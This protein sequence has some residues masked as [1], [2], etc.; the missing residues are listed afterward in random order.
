MAGI[1]VKDLSVV[2]RDSRTGSELKVLDSLNF[3]VDDGKLV[4]IL[5]IS[6]CGK[7]TL[8]YT[9]GGLQKQTSGEVIFTNVRGSKDRVTNMVFQEPALFPW[10]TL[11]S[12]VIFGQEMK[13]KDKREAKERA[14]KYLN[15]LGL[16]GFEDK[17]PIQLSGGMKQRAAIARALTNDPEI[18]LM[19]E[20]FAS[21]DA[22]TRWMMQ[23]Q[24][25]DIQASTRKTILFVTHNIEEAIFLADKVIL[26]TARPTKVKETIEIKIPRPRTWDTRSSPEFVEH[27]RLILAHLKEELERSG[28][29]RNG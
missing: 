29:L 25:L 13:G 7:T 26:L 15:M 16:K 4:C 5:G 27:Y 11:Q 10:R 23:E 9:I 1:S 14:G 28:T 2:F 22:Q 21:V 19:D 18:L 24:L 8:L 6:G 17:Y 20:P 12:N 3:E